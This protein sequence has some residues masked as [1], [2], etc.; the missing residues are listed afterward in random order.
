MK[1]IIGGIGCFG[2]LVLL[3]VGGLVGV[4]FWGMGVV[5]NK[6]YEEARTSITNS[7]AVGNVVGQPVEVGTYNPQKLGQS[8]GGDGTVEYTYEIPVAGSQ[9]SG[10]AIVVVSGNPLD[11]DSWEVV[12]IEVDVDGEKIP[13]GELDLD[14]DID[15]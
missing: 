9:K 12:S 10:T 3:C 15:E 11:G 1:W 5:A 14:I 13:V 2:L 8:P 4:G 7:E 6:A